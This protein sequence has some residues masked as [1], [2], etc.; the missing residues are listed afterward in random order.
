M[1]GRLETWLDVPESLD[2]AS[3][4]HS[5]LVCLLPTSPTLQDSELY[6]TFGMVIGARPGVLTVHDGLRRVQ[7]DPPPRILIHS[8]QL[9]EPAVANVLVLVDEFEG[10]ISSIEFLLNSKYGYALF[11]WAGESWLDVP[12]G[13][14]VREVASAVVAH[15]LAC[16]SLHDWELGGMQRRRM[17][18]VRQDVSDRKMRFV[19][20]SIA[21][22]FADAIDADE[23]AGF[24]ADLASLER[25]PNPGMRA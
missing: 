10:Y 21:A 1:Q 24:H 22:A 20:S 11:A 19:R 5:R 18:R 25:L 23:A 14:S 16:R 8:D 15:L 9:V 3:S 17:R 13:S 2:V 4:P 12:P 6:S 7:Q